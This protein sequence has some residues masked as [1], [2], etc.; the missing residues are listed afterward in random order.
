[1]LEMGEKLAEKFQNKK[2]PKSKLTLDVTTGI[3][4]SVASSQR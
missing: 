1:M 2:I 4:L 3:T